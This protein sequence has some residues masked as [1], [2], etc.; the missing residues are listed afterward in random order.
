M[1]FQYEKYDGTDENGY[2]KFTPAF[3]NI[4]GEPPPPS[5][6]RTQEGAS[7]NAFA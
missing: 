7:W 3:I 5:S 1:I 2:V 4:D 6:L